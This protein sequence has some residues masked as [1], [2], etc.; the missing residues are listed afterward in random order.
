MERDQLESIVKQVLARVQQGDSASAASRP[1]PPAR[2]RGVFK[3]VSDCVGAARQAQLTL[4][5]LP[6]EKRREIIANVRRRCAEDVVNL[7]KMAV[8]ETGLGRVDDKI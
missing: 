3:S 6:L 7:A 5:A 4:V 2:P 1:E 8:E